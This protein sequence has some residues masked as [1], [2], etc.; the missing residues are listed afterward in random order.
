MCF[1]C[2]ENET[3]VRIRNPVDGSVVVIVVTPRPQAETGNPTENDGKVTRYFMLAI[4]Y[5]QVLY[6]H[7]QA[8]FP[9]M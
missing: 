7:T 4:F 3:V 8:R 2:T 9:L 6:R 5:K 1:S